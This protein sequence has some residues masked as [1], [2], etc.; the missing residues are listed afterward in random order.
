DLRPGSPTYG[1]WLG[2]E[3]SAQNRTALYVP[4]DFAH[5]FQTVEDDSEVFYQVS[6][7]YA[8]GAERGIRWDDAWLA[9]A[10]PLPV[11]VVSEKDRSWPDF[12]PASIPAH[13]ARSSA[14]RSAIVAQRSSSCSSARGSPRTSTGTNAIE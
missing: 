13:A 10:W 4:R 1:S 5:G 14:A 3:L 2:V 12:Q 8:P 11:S 7:Y 9:I 6:A